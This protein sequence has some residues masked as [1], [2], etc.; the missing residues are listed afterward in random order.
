MLRLTDSSHDREL[1]RWVSYT[2]PPARSQAAA[3]TPKIEVVSV[4]QRPQGLADVSLQLSMTDALCA[5]RKLPLKQTWLNRKGEWFFLP[6]TV[7]AWR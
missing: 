1:R 5:D 2:P 3:Q 4:Q 6:G 7:A